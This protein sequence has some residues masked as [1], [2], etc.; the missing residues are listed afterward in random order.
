L[1]SDQDLPL[2][3]AAKQALGEVGESV[4]QLVAALVTGDGDPETRALALQVQGKL[5]GALVS[6]T[7]IAQVASA[8]GTQPWGISGEPAIVVATRMVRNAP[9]SAAAVA[10]AVAPLLGNPAW[11]VRLAAV[12]ILRITGDPGLAMTAAR[13]DR[14]SIVRAAAEAK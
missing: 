4:R 13:A 12:R 6:P 10:A 14:N 7:A 5:R 2:S 9:S 3:E 11:E 8:A 1:I